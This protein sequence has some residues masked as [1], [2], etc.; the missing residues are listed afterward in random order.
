MNTPCNLPYFEIHLDKRGD[1]VDAAQVP[2]LLAFLHS[3]PPARDIFVIS[4]G[5]NNNLEESRDL[6]Q[7]FFSQFCATL[8]SYPDC[9][10]RAAEC[11]VV[12]VQWPSEK[13]TD[14]SL[15]PGGA[16]GLHDDGFVYSNPISDPEEGGAASLSGA[17]QD[18]RNHA[19]LLLRTTTFRLM[20]QRAGLIGRT[21]LAPALEQIHHAIPD[22]RLHLLGHSFG[23]R[24]ITA[25]AAAITKPVTTMTLLQA[26]FSHH[27]FSPGFD[28]SYGPG[29]FRSVV[30][31]GKFTG[32]MLVTH[33]N[34]DLAVGLAYPAIS[35]V[36]R[37]NAS[38]LG[39]PGDNYGALGRNGAL[40]TP[41]AIDGELLPEGAPYSFL[42]GRIHNLRADDI[43]AAHSDIVK[44]QT[45]WALI[46]AA[47]GGL[48]P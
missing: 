21:G 1:P 20:K 40:H 41:E 17:L 19:L 28:C 5:W 34:K 10:L 13:Y 25:A 36:L 2:E 8:A 16:A 44:P 11:V 30:T 12:G 29:A 45:A 27:A 47:S 9:G 4:H 33:T 48:K 15:I 22:A 14:P 23:C 18:L 46:S 3:R 37:Q 39:G 7:R 38:G 24:V 42:P 43:I 6:Y 31:E 26:A 32:P 35:R